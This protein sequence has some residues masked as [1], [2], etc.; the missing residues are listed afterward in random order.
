[1]LWSAV[2]ENAYMLVQHGSMGPVGL[3]L[4]KLLGLARAVGVDDDDTLR[5]A[6]YLDHGFREAM[7]EK[8]EQT[9]DGRG[10]EIDGDGDR[11]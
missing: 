9:M 3:D 5:F 10:T 11:A 1:L 6:H 7:A 4:D 8:R 2:K